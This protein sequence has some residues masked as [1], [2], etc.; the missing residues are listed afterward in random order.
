MATT[1]RHVDRGAW[2]SV[3]GTREFGVSGLWRFTDETFCDCDVSD[4]LAEGFAEISVDWIRIEARLAGR[5]IQCG[6]E[7]TTG[8]LTLGRMVETDELR[9]HPVD[10]DA[11]QILSPPSPDSKS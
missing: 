10:A 2:L 8:W 11:V 4:F 1:V 5:C 6:S 3:D 9:F 7:G